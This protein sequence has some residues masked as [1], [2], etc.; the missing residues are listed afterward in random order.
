[1]S[2]QMTAT[3][4]CPMS[5]KS[6]SPLYRAVL[7][8]VIL[9]VAVAALP[10]RNSLAQQAA[11]TE[12]DTVDVSAPGTPF[13]HFW[14]QMFGSGRAVLSMRES[15]RDDLRTVK[16]ATNFKYVRFHGIF[17]DELGVYDEDA[18]GNPIYN[19]S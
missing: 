11:S 4:H 15:Y 3:P 1:M 16:A 12:T 13:P 9:I 19:F 8:L 10:Y 7:L 18:S 6:R 2:E 14:E 17:L 5:K